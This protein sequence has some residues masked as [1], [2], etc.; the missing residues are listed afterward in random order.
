MRIGFIGLGVM[1]G[2]M[3]THLSRAGH[4]LTLLDSDAARAQALAATLQATAVETPA[5][6]AAASE[7][8][9]TMLPDGQ[10]VQTVAF[11]AGGLFEGLQLGSLLLD[12]SSAEPWLTRDTGARLAERGA[13]MVDAPVSGAA[14]GAQAA[15]LVFM[16]GGCDEDVAR[17]RPLLDDKVLGDWNG[18]WLAALAR[19]AGSPAA[20]EAP[21]RA[22]WA[23]RARLDAGFLLRELA[24]GEGD[25]LHRWRLLVSDL[26]GQPVAGAA[27]TVAGHMPGHVHGLPTQPRVTREL[28]PGVYLVEGLKFQ[29]DGWWVMQFDIQ[30]RDAARPADNVAFN[31]VF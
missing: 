23:A 11:G 15:E 13:T 28:A 2:P 6:V 25:R 30:P 10:V 24:D 20:A 27:I 16:V 4:T 26:A 14:W 7:L 5:A 22:G 8:I 21:V 19:A 31:L 29:M 3:A 12:T 1:G 18:Y 9:V 17:V